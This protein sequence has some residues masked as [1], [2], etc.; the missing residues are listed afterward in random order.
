MLENELIT[1]SSVSNRPEIGMQITHKYLMS[2]PDSS[3]DRRYAIE[4]EIVES[5]R[6]WA[7]EDPEAIVFCDDGEWMMDVLDG[8][9]TRA[10]PA[11]VCS[12]IIDGNKIENR[13]SRDF[14]L[15]SGR[16]YVVRNEY[17]NN[18]CDGVATRL[19]PKRH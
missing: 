12:R 17:D 9:E 3:D 6:I 16:V 15:D 11:G 13:I 7:S 18:G 1:V 2:Y 8:D 19:I 10:H 4:D 5:N 14:L